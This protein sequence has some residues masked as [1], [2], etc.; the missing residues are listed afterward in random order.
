MTRVEVKSPR[1]V[2]HLRVISRTLVEGVHRILVLPRVGVN[3]VPISK[4]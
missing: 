4:E 1:R 2:I 3:L